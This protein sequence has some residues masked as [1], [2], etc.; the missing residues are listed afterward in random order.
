M[1]ELI[2][3]LD[4]GPTSIGW[5][6]INQ[7]EQKIVA[8]GVRVFPEGVDRDKSGGEVSKNE[9]RR[10]R[11]GMRRQ[12]RRR[13]KRKQFLKDCL[14]KHGLLPDQVLLQLD[15]PERVKW[16]S[17]AFQAADPYELRARGVIAQLEPFEIGRALL[18][19]N[20]RRGFKSN[21][22]AERSVE[23]ETSEMKLEIESLEQDLGDQTLGTFLNN[24]RGDDQQKY[25][26]TKLRGK[27]TERSMYEYEFQKIC[28]HQRQFYPEILTDN[29][30]EEIQKIIF[31][32]RPLLPPSPGLVGRCELEPRLARCPKADRRAQLFRMYCEVNNLKILDTSSG[33]E[34]PLSAEEREKLVIYLSKSKERTF[35]QIKKHLF[36]QHESIQ[37]NLERGDR[38]KLLGLP[39]DH[40]LASTKRLGKSWWD[41]DDQVKTNII[42]CIIDDDETRLRY[43]LNEAGFDENLAVTVLETRIPQG[44]MSYSLNAI[45]WLLPS[46]QRGVPLTSRS[47]D[48]PCA[49]REAGFL[50][51]WES[52]VQQTKF[53]EMEHMPRL[54][55]P[56]V[57][58][59]LHEVRKVVNAVLREIIYPNA[60]QLKRIH[61]ELAREVRGT[62]IQRAKASKRMRVRNEQRDH[63]ADIIANRGIKVTR[64]AIDRYL[65]WEEQDGDCMYSYPPRKIGLHQ[66]FSGEVDIDHILPRSRSLDNS[67]T[68]KVLCFRSENTAKGQRTVHEWLVGSQ[69]QKYDQIM[70]RVKKLPYPKQ[71]KLLQESVDIDECIARQLNDTTYIATK[72]TEYL[73]HLGVELFCSKGRYTAHMRHHLGLNTILEQ[74]PDSPAWIGGVE[75]PRSQK[76]RADHRHHAIDAI[77]VALTYHQQV[78]LLA[79]QYST[80]EQK[81]QALM[82]WKNFRG[83]VIDSIESINVSHRP[84]RRVRGEL[85]EQKFY[86]GTYNIDGDKFKDQYVIR[87]PLEELTLNEISHIRDS[88]IRQLITKRVKN[89]GYEV[90]RGKKIPNKTWKEIIAEPLYVTPKTGKQSNLATP[91]KKVRV[92]KN[93]QTFRPIRGDKTFVKPGSI[94]HAC[95]FELEQ[96]QKKLTTIT[97]CSLIE[98]AERKRE[99]Q[100]QKVQHSVI[101]KQH[102]QHPEA[103]FLMSLCKGD[104][105]LAKINGT[106]KLVVVRKF[107]SSKDQPK[108]TVVDVA[109]ARPASTR[110]DFTRTPNSLNAIQ[111]VSIDPLGRIRKCND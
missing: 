77:V 46:L 90:G 13:A 96:K 81:H 107:Q 5:A 66:L 80:N 61:I 51:P 58:A 72:V 7:A 47:A 104:S 62:S 9:N 70:Q 84:R 50:M 91:V 42:A 27:H 26:L 98:A 111:K 60:H 101:N 63:A 105:L 43:Y 29:V 73:K 6:L 34:R 88:R 79:G 15:H 10:I 44:Y 12:L 74:L 30:I 53:L 20:Q 78:R 24:L 103:K 4:L 97:F 22:K 35:A 89:K 49:L 1:A 23:N 33:E 109:D 76:N 57:Q 17:E 28:E 82:P 59:A 8:S 39:V 85:H 68:N 87:K 41:V 93:D 110:K 56:I 19:L 31:H 2:L 55:N 54:A 16:E 100:R 95:L 65:L 3:G 21:R 75:L 92:L 32:Q 86:G 67:F 83:D 69:D 25:H 18:H 108:I 11:R 14:V 102:P 48:T 94:H 40:A 45:K 71:L 37:F 99:N 64:D 52:T 106:E 38:T 36:E